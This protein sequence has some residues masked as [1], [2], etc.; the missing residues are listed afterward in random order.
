MRSSRLQVWFASTALITSLATQQAIAAPDG[1]RP[2]TCADDAI[3]VFDASGSMAGPGFGEDT[4]TRMEKARQALRTVLPAIAPA[5]NIGLII[6]GP[7]NS[8]SCSNIELKLAPGPNSAAS[9]MSFI[10]EARPYGQTPLTDAVRTAADALDY[11]RRQATIVLLT[12]GEETCSGNPCKAG[13]EL[14]RQGLDI[15]IHVIG[16]MTRFAS[17][18]GSQQ[19]ARCFSEQT[20]GQYLTAESTNELISALQKTLGCGQLSG[21]PRRSH[22][23][24]SASR[25]K[26]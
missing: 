5:R 16:Y 4:I 18:S 9:L 24:A 13:L 22:L 14:E 15:T 23:A 11:R 10:D 19:S 21:A 12:D 20:G 1:A 3:I 6:Y 2:N 8:N 25:P 17:Q 26:P 7:G